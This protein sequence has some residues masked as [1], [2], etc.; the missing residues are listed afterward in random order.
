[1]PNKRTVIETNAT[2][3]SVKEIKLRTLTFN[4]LW[5]NYP[6]GNPY[7]N[8]AYPDQCAIRL[9]VAFHRVGISGYEI[10]RPF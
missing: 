1:M 9:S 6:S 7:D 8:P 3:N 5:E 2:P 10:K 4:E